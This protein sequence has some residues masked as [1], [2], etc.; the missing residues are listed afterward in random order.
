MTFLSS[1]SFKNLL[2]TCCLCPSSFPARTSNAQ[3][4]AK[5]RPCFSSPNSEPEIL[6]WYVFSPAKLQVCPFLT[7]PFVLE[8]VLRLLRVWRDI[9]IELEIFRF[10]EYEWAHDERLAPFEMIYVEETVCF[11]DVGTVHSLDF[12]RAS[13]QLGSLPCISGRNRGH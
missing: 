6:A 7:R 11:R 12:G 4:V 13:H 8:I 3:S 2:L 10:S 5:R 1:L 9:P